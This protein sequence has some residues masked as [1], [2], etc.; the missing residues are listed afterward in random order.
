MNNDTNRVKTNEKRAREIMGRNF[1]GIE[2]GV[3]H[4][5]VNPTHR[6]LA[7][8]S[9]IPF[10]KEVLERLRNTHVLVAVFPLS[11]IEIR[12]IEQEL[13]YNHYNCKD[14]WYSKEFFAKEYGE[15][16][17]QLVRKTPV[18]NSFSKNWQEQ[19]ALLSKDDEVLNAQVMIYTIFGYYLAT[20]ERLFE[21]IYVRTSSVASNGERV[22]VGSFNS[23]GLA[24]GSYWADDRSGY[25]GV[26]SAKLPD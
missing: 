17:W 9:K 8:L 10:S 2:E 26:S 7:T 3:K 5:G 15:V 24:V 12:S 13:F 6:Q 20:G 25:L 22:H 11:I 21:N 16:T 23:G 1:F 19:Q 18:N 14:T 4:F